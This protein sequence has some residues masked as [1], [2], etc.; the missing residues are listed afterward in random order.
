[1]KHLWRIMVISLLV[2]KASVRRYTTPYKILLWVFLR[3]KS[4]EKSENVGL[5]KADCNF[6][7]KE[8]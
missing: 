5:N 8:C 7:G 1:M 3:V 6:K 4:K 2:P